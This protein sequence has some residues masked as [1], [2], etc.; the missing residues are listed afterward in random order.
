MTAAAGK[1]GATV[2]PFKVRRS[3]RDELGNSMPP[4]FDKP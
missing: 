3:S 2:V 1:K 4:A